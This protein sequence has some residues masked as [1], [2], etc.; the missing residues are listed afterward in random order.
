MLRDATQKMR[1]EAAEEVARLNELAHL[2]TDDCFRGVLGEGEVRGRIEELWGYK[3]PLVFV[4]EEE[5]NVNQ[6]RND[7][8]MKKLDNTEEN[9]FE[10]EGNTVSLVNDIQL[11]SEEEKYMKSVKAVAKSQQ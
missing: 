10:T 4:S 5:N 6:P 1:K 7:Q 2:K 3:L 8:Y 11:L 9:V